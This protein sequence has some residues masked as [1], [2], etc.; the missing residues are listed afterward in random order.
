VLPISQKNRYVWPVI[1]GLVSWFLPGAGYFVLKEQKRAVILF[2]AVSLTF[3][4]G[5]YVGSIGV[6]DPIDSWPWY[7]A[8]V[9]NSPLVFLLGN[10]VKAGGYPVYGRPQEIGQIYTSISGLLN[11]LCIVNAVYLA[12]LSTLQ[13]KE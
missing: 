3:L 12:Y 9:M 8:Q 2:L 13:T 4:L 10:Y 1:V 5:I 11:L 6:V 7:I